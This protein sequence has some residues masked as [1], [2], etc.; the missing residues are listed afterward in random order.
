YTTLFR[1]KDHPFHPIRYDLTISLLEYV[2]ALSQ[3]DILEPPKYD[4]E[5]LLLLGHQESYIEAIKLLST[6]Q[7]PIHLKENAEL[8]GL[9]ADD[10]P[11]FAGMHEAACSIRSEEHTSELQS[12]ENLVCRLLLEKKNRN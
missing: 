4:M 6:T 5:D 9:Q 8:Y 10:T 2:G 3:T 11:Y 7:P 1:S 12:R